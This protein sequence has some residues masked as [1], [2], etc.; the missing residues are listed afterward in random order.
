VRLPRGVYPEWRF[1]DRLRMS[2]DGIEMTQREG[3]AM[4]GTYFYATFFVYP[5]L[6][7]DIVWD[8]MF[9]ISDLWGVSRVWGYGWF[10]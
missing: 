5:I 6:K 2:G 3:F 9:G 7:L 10:S 4:T 1:F 8:L